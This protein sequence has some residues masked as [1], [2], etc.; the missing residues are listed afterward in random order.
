MALLLEETA[1]YKIQQGPFSLADVEVLSILISGS[2]ALE[3]ARNVLQSTSLKN[4][5]RCSHSDL[6]AMGLSV[7]EANRVLAAFEI[8]RRKS[9]ITEDKRP[10][11]STSKD[12]YNVLGP[13]IEDLEIEEFWV[14]FVNKANKI[15]GKKKIAI[16]GQA[17]VVVDIKFVF[18]AA[19]QAKA[20]AIICFHNHPS[21]SLKPSIQDNQI[22]KQI[23]DAG[24]AL[25]IQLLDHLI[26]SSEGYYSFADEGMI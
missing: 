15:T 19:V 25:D 21:G 24:K 9:A 2:K 22:T 26:V 14:A 6:T 20:A 8:G 16:G 3:K 10:Y 5:S 7:C 1:A 23:K 12:A 4:L 17:G 13:L 18:L 11:I